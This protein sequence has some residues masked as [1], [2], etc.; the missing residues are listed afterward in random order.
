M[1][2]QIRQSNLFAAEDWKV[3]YEAFRKIDLKAYD[4]DTIRDAM[5]NHLRTTY[6]DNFNDWIG[7]QEFIFILDTLCFLGQNLAFRMDLNT[8]ENFIDTAERRESVLRLANM[9]S[10]SPRRNYPS[11]G[12]VKVTEITTSMDV[13]DSNGNSLAGRTIKWDDPLN[14]DWYEQFILVMN[15]NFSESNPFGDPVKRY[16][17]EGNQTHLY[18]LR[19]LEYSS[20]AESFTATVNGQSMGFEVVN[21]DIA[22]DGVIE[23]RHPNPQESRFIIYK[24]DGNG[25]ASPDTGFFMMFKQGTL[26]F[27]DFLFSNSI[28]SRVQEIDVAD[29]NEIDV[30]CQQI[31]TE[32]VVS[33]EWTKVP[34]AQNI[35]YNS[36]SQQ[37]KEIFSVVTR[38]DDQISIR[39]PDSASG[40]IPR[41][42]F[43]IWYRVSNGLSYTI[44]T[45]DMQNKTITYR[46]RGADQSANEE[47]SLQ[48]SFSLQYQV[49]NSQAQET[50][51]Q[52]RVRAPQTYY[53]SNRLITGEDYNIGPMSQGGNLVRKAKAINRTYS[54]H[55][56][57]IDVN[58]PTGKY[59]NTNIFADDG[60]I[61]REWERSIKRSS[62]IIPSTLPESAIIAQKLQ[63][64]LSYTG[65]RQLF[66]EQTGYWD[67]TSTDYNDHA[68]FVISTASLDSN[69]PNLPFW[70]PIS[71]R[72]PAGTVGIIE[73]NLGQSEEPRA[74]VNFEVGC[75]IR[76]VD[77][78][79]NPTDHVWVTV[80][81]TDQFTDEVQLSGVVPN[82]WHADRYYPPMRTSFNTNEMNRI[83]GEMLKNADFGLTYNPLS[84]EWTIVEMEFVD[85]DKPFDVETNHG[86]IKVEYRSH[87]WEFT[88]RGVDYVFVGG[89]HVKFFFVNTDKLSDTNS[90]I[91]QQDFI[92]ILKSNTNPNNGNLAYD[93]DIS[94]F[95]DAEYS[96]EDGRVDPDRVSIKSAERDAYDIPTRPGVFHDIV[97]ESDASYEDLFWRIT[98]ETEEYIKVEDDDEF[99]IVTSNGVLGSG[100][101]EYGKVFYYEPLDV[102]I[103]N[104]I[105]EDGD[106]LAN[107]VSS[108]LIQDVIDSEGG[109]VQGF[110]EAFNYRRRQGRKNIYY[111]WKHFAAN[112]YRIDPAITN[113][114]DMYVLTTTFADQVTFWA[115]S[116][117][118]GEMPKPPTATELK[119]DFSDV[120]QIK[121]VSDSIV[122]HSG[123]FVPLFGSNSRDEYRATFRVVRAPGSRYSDDEIRQQVIRLINEYFE[124][125]NWD[126]GETFY[127]TELSTYIHQQLAT[128]ISSV[129]IVPKNAAVKFG[130]LFQIA[131]EPSELFIST[132]KVEDV[133]IVNALTSGNIQIGR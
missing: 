133:E 16:N 125:D 66:D 37:I 7:N 63:P 111:Q 5:I 27:D 42:E 31:T 115:N 69:I 106:A 56:H 80:V 114:M 112:D 29:I 105:R 45:T 103:Q 98:E 65:L 104:D 13:R 130:T 83:V 46:T 18:R 87:S 17:T 23:E 19:T 30:W 55:S 12:L 9:L 117:N 41:G 78:E 94:F 21:P 119:R 72:T 24:N 25:F 59:Q 58:D 71:G 86:L 20:V 51:D 102:F 77:D 92:K 67:H 1:A 2:T 62:E 3:V 35:M 74:H 60:V 85:F 22:T 39:F 32:G 89:E 124:I 64:L 36:V 75:M 84:R 108:E 100:N 91:A 123:S 90:G 28:E 57:F 116:I 79:T 61:Y 131:C 82:R 68:G 53:T 132:A 49:Q 127:F 128:D 44:K 101:N 118:P 4:F 33:Q 14:P 54:G 38:D 126:F 73:P 70:D 26:K 121:A 50:I 109:N 97:N 88:V 107:V 43:R 52:I 93:D 96:N 129:V 11:R 10:Y 120:E 110:I 81:A 48:I 113:I 95:V 34:T 76:F 40:T 6:P 8:R 99:F 47:S 122:W 15:A